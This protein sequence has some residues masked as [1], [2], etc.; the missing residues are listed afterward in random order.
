MVNW[1]DWWWWNKNNI[2]T[3]EHLNDTYTRRWRLRR[4]RWRKRCD[5]F[6][7]IAFSSVPS[8]FYFNALFFLAFFL[9]S[10]SRSRSTFYFQ[11]EFFFF[12]FDG[13]VC[14]VLVYMLHFT[15][16]YSLVFGIE[17]HRGVFLSFF[18]LLLC[19]CHSSHWIWIFHFIYWLK[20]FV[21][22]CW[23]PQR[24]QLSFEVPHLLKIDKKKEEH[25]INVALW[26]S[27]C[28]WVSLCARETFVSSPWIP[29]Q[30][31]YIWIICIYI[32]YANYCKRF[33]T[34]TSHM[35]YVHIF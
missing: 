26:A 27:V 8:Y 2:C 18:L 11:T 34:Y 31:R 9:C 17:R 32:P 13:C 20:S 29:I 10:S 16:T 30:A 35:R 12:D 14:V 23:L 25:K 24:L 33:D 5:D 1:M 7:F 4:W 28:V 21:C 19:V 22:K 6:K 15:L 3:F